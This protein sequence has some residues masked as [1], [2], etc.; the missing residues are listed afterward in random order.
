[1]EAIKKALFL[2][3][4]CRDFSQ[5]PKQKATQFYHFATLIL[6]FHFS[7]FFQ[8]NRGPWSQNFPRLFI[9]PAG[10]LRRGSIE[11]L[12]LQPL[13]CI[14][15]HSL[16]FSLSFLLSLSSSFFFSVFLFSAF[17]NLEATKED[18]RYLD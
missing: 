17:L 8:K 10:F 12:N 15:K 9:N 13:M 1:M 5:T 18:F 7:K 11:K 4:V 3:N 6:S 2:N 16:F 14:N